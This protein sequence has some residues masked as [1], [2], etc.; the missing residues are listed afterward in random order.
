MIKKIIEYL[1]ETAD[2]LHEYYCGEQQPQLI[3]IKMV[4]KHCKTELQHGEEHKC[5]HRG[6]EEWRK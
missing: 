5:L 4:C 6:I 1:N 3:P 2:M